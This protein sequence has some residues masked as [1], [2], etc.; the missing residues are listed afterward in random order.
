[1]V[2]ISATS[3]RQPV[4]R[5]RRQE[6]GALVG[7]A[8]AA[9]VASVAC[10]VP[11]ISSASGLFVADE[12]GQNGGSAPV[13]T[14]E[15]GHAAEGDG[16]KVSVLAYWQP[17]HSDDYSPEAG[18]EFGAL[19]VSLCATRRTVTNSVFIAVMA[20]GSRY[21][22]VLAELAGYQPLPAFADLAPGDCLAGWVTLSVPIGEH[23][24]QL[25]EEG[26]GARIDV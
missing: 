2:A 20:G 11:V 17:V 5:A 21:K 14:G 25:I 18:Q 6:L 13:P 24:V 9:L 15:V 4:R 1:M 12:A 23:P 10:H 3:Y 7:V 19:H 16:L 26:S 22:S 8:L